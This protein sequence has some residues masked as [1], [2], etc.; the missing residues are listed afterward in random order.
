[1][2]ALT[3]DIGGRRYRA[4][5]AA[6]RS[7]AIRLDFGGAQPNFFGAAAAEAQTYTAG[8]FTGDTHRGGSCNVAT[9]RLTP[10]CNGTHTECIGHVVDGGMTLAEAQVPPFMPATLVSIAV[11]EGQ[12]IS[13]DALEDVLPESPARQFHYALIVRTLPNSAEKRQRAYTGESPP[14]WFSVDA[15]R[16]IRKAG[17]EHL[18]VDLP[19]LDAMDDAALTAH[20]IFWGLPMQSRR[21]GD[22]QHPHATI[23]EMI[24]VPDDIADG[25][26]LLNLQLPA[27]ATDAAP[28][29]PVIFP[30]EQL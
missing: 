20:R 30:L 21:L 18:L 8:T 11:D 25:R 19:S 10:H 7:L 22:A 5:S 17:I 24:Y 26:Y 23:T 3:L 9:Y 4:D 29:Q 16:L 12:A 6:G 14:A 27:F 15:M 2:S 13:R 1:M 28:S